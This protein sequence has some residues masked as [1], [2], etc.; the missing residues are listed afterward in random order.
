MQPQFIANKTT[1]TLTARASTAVMAIIEKMLES[2]DKPRAEVIIDV[3]ILEVSR[4]R[5]KRTA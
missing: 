2:N 3:Q 4:E 1:N 5:A